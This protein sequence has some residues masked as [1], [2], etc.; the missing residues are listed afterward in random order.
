MR[1]FYAMKLVNLTISKYFYIFV[2]YHNL[3]QFYGTSANNISLNCKVLIFW[4]IISFR[5]HST[6]LLI[7]L[8]QIFIPYGKVTS[9]TMVLC[10]WTLLEKIQ[11]SFLL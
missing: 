7:T 2:T 10:N 4:L 3:A 1:N 11:N 5:I 8:C 6:I 9:N